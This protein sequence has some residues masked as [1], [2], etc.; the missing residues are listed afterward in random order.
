MSAITTTGGLIVR[1]DS[2]LRVHRW[3]VRPVEGLNLNRSLQNLSSE[4]CIMFISEPHD[5]PF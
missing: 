3:Y 5:M 1:S 4:A 2:G